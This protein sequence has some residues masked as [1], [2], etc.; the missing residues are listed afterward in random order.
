MLGTS[1]LVVLSADVSPERELTM[2]ESESTT[3]DR[4]SE[5]E[6][7]E[8]ML[9]FVFMIVESTEVF[10][11]ADESVAIFPV[12]ANM[13]V[14]ITPKSMVQKKCRMLISCYF[15]IC[16]LVFPNRLSLCW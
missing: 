3:L 1:S 6:A 12:W 10:C 5:T 8:S 11:M 13:E 14:V 2:E 4:E 9:V 15:D 16:S 7:N